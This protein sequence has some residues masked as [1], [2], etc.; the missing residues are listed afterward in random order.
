MRVGVAAG[1]E[2]AELGARRPPRGPGTPTTAGGE[3]AA[4]DHRH[5]R[6]RRV[7]AE[8]L[9]PSTARTRARRGRSG[10]RGRRPSSVRRPSRAAAGS[11]SQMC[12]AGSTTIS[13]NGLTPS[14][15]GGEGQAEQAAR[16][17]ARCARRPSSR[18]CAR[19]A[20]GSR[21]ARTGARRRRRS[22]CPASSRRCAPAAGRRRCR[23]A[24]ARRGAASSHMAA[25]VTSH[26]P[27]RHPSATR[28]GAIATRRRRS[29]AT[30][31]STQ[32]MNGA[33]RIAIDASASQPRMTFPDRSST[34]EP[35]RSIVGAVSSSATRFA[36]V[37]PTRPSWPASRAESG[38]RRAW[39]RAGGQRE[40]RDPVREQRALLARRVRDRR[41][42]RAGRRR[43]G[44]AA[45]LPYQVGHR[46]PCGRV[47]RWARRP[48][49]CSA[50]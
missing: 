26:A 9:R 13:A 36:T 42:P 16:Q 24:A 50:G 39:P 18:G 14:G 4:R 44:C 32:A 22:G 21:T 40:R 12:A 46:L 37:V 47:Q 41:S 34:G 2:R 5:E 28:P 38:P 27:A 48:A 15:A 7:R 8:P 20:A 49:A 6:P 30:R 23:G 35:S 33:S 29:R 31:S 43:R 11:H 25:S 1:D 3:V 17:A 10:R 45:A 19:A